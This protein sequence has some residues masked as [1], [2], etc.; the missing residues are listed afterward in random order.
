VDREALA[1]RALVL[2]A[3]YGTRLSELT[4]ETPKPM[5]DLEGH[6]I[7][8]VILAN[9]ARQEIREVAVNL[10]FLPEA[11]IAGI[12][13]GAEL[14]LRIHYIHEREL[15]GTLGAAKNIEGYLGADGTFLLHYGDVVTD[16][17][18][19]QLVAMQAERGAL[20][21][22]LVHRRRGS[23]S[24]AVMEA[25]GRVSRF[26]ER[27]TESERAGVLSEWA[28]SGIAVLEP[29][30]LGRIR[31]GPSDL[32]RDMLPRLADEGSL[33]AVP[34]TGYR[35]AVD[36]PERLETTRADVRAGRCRT[37]LDGPPSLP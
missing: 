13:D 4:A 2:S 14:G 29:R 8:S 16:Q 21:T 35:C 34:L 37:F 3:G 15:L 23:N 33:Y 25:D 32:P 7:L 18:F 36:S 19:G 17:D 12:G 22:I 31:P 9:L 11:V 5:L 20:A 28:F 6:P 24:V 1:M 26:L 30:V 27:P 10:H